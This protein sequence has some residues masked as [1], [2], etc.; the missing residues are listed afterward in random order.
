MFWIHFRTSDTRVKPCRNRVLL[1]FSRESVLNS[2]DK[3]MN[4][5]G[6]DP[7]RALDV[8]GAR[9][10]A[11]TA[12]ASASHDLG[13]CCRWIFHLNTVLHFLYSYGTFNEC[14]G[15]QSV[16]YKQDRILSK[17]KTNILLCQTINKLIE[18]LF[19]RYKI[20]II[21]IFRSAYLRL[22]LKMYRQPLRWDSRTLYRL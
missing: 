9:P 18:T 13:D 6:N 14:L 17:N 7:A 15:I 3:L 8:S 11:A 12:T 1:F 4:E 19:N 21:I 16:H 22:I 20:I 2:P 10:C 5:I